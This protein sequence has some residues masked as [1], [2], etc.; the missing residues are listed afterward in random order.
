MKKK[1][2]PPLVRA[3]TVIYEILQTLNHEGAV[4]RRLWDLIWQPSKNASQESFDAIPLAHRKGDPSVAPAALLVASGLQAVTHNVTISV[5]HDP[6]LLANPNLQQLMG[7]IEACR[8][9][10]AFAKHVEDTPPFMATVEPDGSVTVSNY[11]RND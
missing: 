6:T 3:H 2:D 5:M 8:A 7:A 10:S 4:F 9:D 11:P 1:T